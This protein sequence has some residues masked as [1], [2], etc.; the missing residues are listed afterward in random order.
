MSSEIKIKKNKRYEMI[1]PN[2]LLLKFS[3]VKK[4]EQIPKVAKKFPA[5][6]SLPKTP[7]YLSQFAIYPFG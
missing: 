5:I 6:Y 1:L 4:K 2:G 3:S 7:A